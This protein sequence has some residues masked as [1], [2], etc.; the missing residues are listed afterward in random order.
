MSTPV[1][2]KLQTEDI[3]QRL[4]S[5]TPEQ[6]A[7]FDEKE[8]KLYKRYQKM[9]PHRAP[10][11]DEARE[12]SKA[13]M[14]F[15]YPPE[16]SEAVDLSNANQSLVSKGFINLSK[17]LTEA[18]FPANA[19]FFKSI[20]RPK[21][22]S[23]L[24]VM[25]DSAK[26]AGNREAEESMR[27]L[28]SFLTNGLLDR[29]EKLRD[30]IKASPDA[31]TFYNTILHAVFSGTA[32]FAKLTLHDSKTYTLE[33]FVSDF[34]STGD[35]VEVIVRDTIHFSKFDPA[36]LK[37]LFGTSDPEKFEQGNIEEIPIFTR[38]VR[39]FDHWE[40][41]VE[42]AGKKFDK[43]SGKEDLDSPPFIVIP[44]LLMPKKDYGVS[45][46][47]NNAGD[48]YQYENMNLTMNIMSEAA[49]KVLA[50]LPAEMKI[51]K[52]EV[53]NRIGMQFLYGNPAKAQVLLADISKNMGAI[54]G[55]YDILR[56][57]LMVTFNMNEAVVRDAERVTQEEIQ[58]VI[59]G[60][61]TLLGGLFI[62]IARR[63]QKPY[64]TRV[65]KLAV[66][67]GEIPALPEDQADVVLTAGQ[68]H[69]DAMEELKALD[70]WLA[71][72]LQ[73]GEE[74]LA[75]INAEELSLRYA[76]PLGVPVEGLMLTDEQMQEKAG[77]RELVMMAKQFG[78][79]GPGM[80]A[81]MIGQQLQQA[82][83]G[84]PANEQT[85]TNP[86]Q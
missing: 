17:K 66:L 51:S 5:A 34:D 6:E 64:I 62:S 63:Y 25:L 43:M 2:H 59:E 48:I 21:V 32:C 67:A 54:Q 47:T 12:M 11:L 85:A 22:R 75:R 80:M 40:I 82:Q 76:N 10:Y 39:R 41:E 4:T 65:N 29:D 13:V 36:D 77:V 58:T 86:A 81:Q 37:A 15:M 26:E 1:N 71:R 60:L 50:I 55:L 44:F 53:E 7:L 56:Q 30:I 69:I 73:L 49:S 19:K 46:A 38:Q 52:A 35:L 83:G 42:V 57:T 8:G 28:A 74:G 72:V 20:V 23:E 9:T 84:A 31:E 45:W 68:E 33:D 61:K 27:S 14:P 24:E 18:I 3:K 79:Q 16:N 70:A 78:P